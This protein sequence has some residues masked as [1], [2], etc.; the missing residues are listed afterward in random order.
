MPIFSARADHASN[1][2]RSPAG[3]MRTDLVA[4]TG[5]PGSH[6]PNCKVIEQDPHSVLAPHFH[7]VN[8]FQIVTAGS[9]SIGRRPV[10]PLTVHFA[11][12]HTPY[13]PIQ[14]DAEGLTYVVM[15]DRVDSGAEWMPEARARLSRTTRRR[16]VVSDSVAPTNAA[17]LA[18]LATPSVRALI[19]EEADGLAVLLLS[20]P[21]GAAQPCPDPAGGGGQF[22]LVTAGQLVQHDRVLDA[23]S[24]IH[25]SAQEEPLALH[26]DDGGAEILFLQF[27]Q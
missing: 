21:Q 14:A 20:L 15:R 10:R 16:H 25:V 4:E 1:R 26:V 2:R 11:G 23:G 7:A 19:P 5:A 18:T 8:Q 12:S 6:V 27:P 9:G 3:V 13:G 22:L 17:A 24:C